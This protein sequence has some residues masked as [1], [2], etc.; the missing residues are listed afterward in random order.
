MS[1]YAHAYLVGSLIIFPLWL[2]LLYHRKDLAREL[3][4]MSII[5]GLLAILFAPPF[6]HDYWHPTYTLPL[7]SFGGI[8]DF[9]YG[10]FIVG[11][12]SVVYEELFG[13][14]FVKRKGRKKSFS[15][16]V[17]PALALYGLAFYLPVYLGLPSI[18]AALFSF[19]VLA[20][21][22]VSIR[23]DLLMDA[24]VSGLVVGSLTLLGFILFLKIYPA[25]VNRF[26]DLDGVNSFSFIGIPLGELLW[27]F[28]LG[29]AS[30]PVYEFFV[31]QRFQ[32]RPSKTRT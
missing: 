25:V 1:D 4:T 23:H 12:A 18:Y 29:A 16:F 32:K 30:G 15:R 17:L 11:I 14:K 19:A 2:L 3:F 7:W 20:S 24:L 31:G 10:F 6:L 9:I 5:G 22:I 28:G 13:K 27:A 26:W 8:E 21:V